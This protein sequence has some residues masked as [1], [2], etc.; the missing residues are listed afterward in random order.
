M[1][2]RTARL[3][4]TVITVGVAAAGVG[5]VPGPAGADQTVSAGSVVTLADKPNGVPYFPDGRLYGYGFTGGVIGAAFSPVE[6]DPNGS[7]VL[8]AA[9]GAELAVIRLELDVHD[10]SVS[11]LHK[12]NVTPTVTLIAGSARVPLP[13]RGGETDLA[14]GVPKGAPVSVEIAAD[15]FVQSLD[16]RT[17]RHL[18]PMPPALYRSADKLFTTV[19]ANTTQTLNATD[20][21]GAAVPFQVTLKNELFSFFPPAVDPTPPDPAK[22]YLLVELDGYGPEKLPNGDT[23]TQ[24]AALP[25]AKMRLDLPDGTNVTARHVDAVETNSLFPGIYYFPVPARFAHGRLGITP[26]DTF[27]AATSNLSASGTGATKITFTSTASFDVALPAETPATPPATSIPATP[28]AALRKHHS[29]GP[30]VWVLVALVLVALAG[31]AAV[32]R[33]R[34]WGL[35]VVPVTHTQAA[36]LAGPGPRPLRSASPGLELPAGAT[37][38][39]ATARPTPPTPDPSAAGDPLLVLS[40][41]GPLRVEGLRKPIRRK[42]VMRLLML[43]AINADRALSSDQLRFA[44][45]T[46]D[47][48]EPAENTV[49]NYAF[50][51]RQALP[52]G[53]LPANQPGGYRLGPRFEL[54]W[55]IFQ[56]LVAQAAANPLD[57]PRL[58]ALALGMIRGEPLADVTW[59]GI[60]PDVR[61]IVT[62]IETVA[63]DAAAEALGVGE[64]RAAETAIVQGLL[65]SPGCPGLWEDRLLAAAAGS[66]YGLDRAWADAQQALAGD[67]ALIEATYRR[68]RG[69]LV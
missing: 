57:R 28:A 1:T 41:L 27:E 2:S 15:G 19:P 44:L 42:P 31:I 16:L 39:D 61:R 64:A 54:D 50:H 26:A 9:A 11:W 47:D 49:H 24:I 37:V 51:L 66:G 43:L 17:G 69:A 22:A 67:A 55:A 20:P 58:L 25:A 65:A 23:I 56:S 29:S 33:R 21:T 7:G 48:Q 32:V 13:T 12:D 8:T 59:P 18:T 38:I 53:L 14:V 45:A 60:E 34:R 62:T 52:D 46:S 5:V 3:L 30:A 63:R 35:P 10:I 68:L 36:L 40:I 6:N 4:R